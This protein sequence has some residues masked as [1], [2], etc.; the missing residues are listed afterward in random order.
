MKIG[1]KVRF[2]NNIGFAAPIGS[3]ARIV[4]TEA[5]YIQIEWI[6][7]GNSDQMD[8]CYSPERFEVIEEVQNNKTVM[9]KQKLTV[10]ITDVLEIHRIAC[11]NWKETIAKYLSR[12]DSDQEITFDQEEVD[13][14]FKAA[15]TSQLPKLED[16]FGAQHKEY[17]LKDI[18]DGKLLFKE[19]ASRYGKAGMIEVRSVDE[20]KDKAFWLNY[21]YNW[22][23]KRDSNGVLVLIPTPKY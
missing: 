1:D 6:D 8:G 17:T 9:L 15:T 23:I 3:T 13:A 11:S 7:N 14:M 12:V 19:D 10:S 16:I 21:L 20:Y 4:G 2:T 22:E 18:A 5:P